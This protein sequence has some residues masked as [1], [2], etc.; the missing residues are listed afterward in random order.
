MRHY[1]ELLQALIPESQRKAP[2]HDLSFKKL[3]CCSTPKQLPINPTWREDTRPDGDLLQGTGGLLRTRGSP[4]AQP[5]WASSSKPP[6]KA[7]M[8]ERHLHL[9]PSCSAPGRLA[10][11]TELHVSPDSE[12]QGP[13]CPSKHWAPHLLSLMS[14][15]PLQACLY[16]KLQGIPA[17]GIPSSWTKMQSLL[18]IPAV[19]P[20]LFYSLYSA[21]HM[22]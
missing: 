2:E 5:D 15:K 6:W 16:A 10:L 7:R 14:S 21:Y 13:S 4:V 11:G 22:V 9:T 8:M 12:K 18:C 17:S 1:N 20:T 3:S 19:L